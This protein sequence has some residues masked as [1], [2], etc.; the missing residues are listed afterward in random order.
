MRN[1]SGGR[2]HMLFAARGRLRGSRRGGDSVRA[3]EAGPVHGCVVVDYG[4]VDIRVID[5]GRVHVGDCGVI[6]EMLAHPHSATESDTGISEPIIHAAVEAD[7]RAPVSGVPSVV[8]ASK[9]PIA[10]SP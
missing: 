4:L 2:C 10:G 6:A 8:A 5:D 3:V 7:V 1:L 9:S